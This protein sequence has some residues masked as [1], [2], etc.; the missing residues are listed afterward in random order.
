[1]PRMPR[2][3]VF[4]SR[5]RSADARA[6][7]EQPQEA[8]AAAN[9]ALDRADRSLQ[10]AEHFVIQAT[11]DL[12]VVQFL[13]V[14]RFAEFEGSRTSDIARLAVARGNRGLLIALRFGALASRD[15]QVAARAALSALRLPL[16]GNRR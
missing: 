16:E 3:R 14:A 4:R 11:R 1:M 7:A 10:L 6:D 2:R 12:Q 5:R 13:P 15:H 8:M 9:I